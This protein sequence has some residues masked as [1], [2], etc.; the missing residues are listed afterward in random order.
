M[1]ISSEVG[2]TSLTVLGSAWSLGS[3]KICPSS[4]SL[5]PFL[6]LSFV[7]SQMD[8]VGKGLRRS[9]GPTPCSGRATSNRQA[10]QGRVRSGF[11]YFQ[12][13]KLRSLPK[14][15]GLASFPSPCALLALV[16]RWQRAPA[17]V[18]KATSLSLGH[19]KQ[20]KSW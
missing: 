17:N 7:Q 12:G 16:S 19:P 2:S 10:V 18:S 13:R 11:P 4:P 14:Q 6:P 1:L 9:S 3:Q 15:P 8:E 5:L 20:R